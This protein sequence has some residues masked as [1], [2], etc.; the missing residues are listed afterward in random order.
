M[1]KLMASRRD[2]PSLRALTGHHLPLLQNVLDKGSAAIHARFGVARD[3]LRIYLH[4][5]V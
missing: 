1:K 4:Y 5:Q 3:K 2:L